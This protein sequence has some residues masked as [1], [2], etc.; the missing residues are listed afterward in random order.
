MNSFPGPG[1]RSIFRKFELPD[2]ATYFFKENRK[3]KQEKETKKHMRK[4]RA[5]NRRNTQNKKT[6]AGRVRPPWG[7]RPSQNVAQSAQLVWHK[8]SPEPAVCVCVSPSLRQQKPYSV[9]LLRKK[10]PPG[11]S[12][13]F[14]AVDPWAHR[15][16][17]LDCAGGSWGKRKHN[18]K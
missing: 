5:N 7:T 15:K 6:V 1:S 10:G 8:V 17:F 4:A 13:F 2:G 12:V 18:K 3:Q 9:P 11:F 16:L 14:D